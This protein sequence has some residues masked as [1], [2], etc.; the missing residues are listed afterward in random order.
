[1]PKLGFCIATCPW[2]PTLKPNVIFSSA[3]EGSLL[4]NSFLV[5]KV[6]LEELI[7]SSVTPSLRG[8]EIGCGQILGYPI[9]AFGTVA[10]ASASDSGLGSSIREI[11][12]LEELGVFP[13]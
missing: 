5:C 6:R 2:L 3:L 11:R 9:G 7:V 4:Y 8:F 13:D 1:M 12:N 10:G